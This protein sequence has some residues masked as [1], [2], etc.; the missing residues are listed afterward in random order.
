[1]AKSKA[2]KQREKWIR[3]GHLDPVM[4]RSPFHTLDLHTRI[5][6]TKKDKLYQKK[7]KNLSRYDSEDGF[8][9][10]KGIV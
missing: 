10:V 8:L 4:K 7:R 1:M 3:E 5:T 9:F 2:K 6:K